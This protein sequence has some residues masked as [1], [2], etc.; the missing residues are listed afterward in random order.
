MV[1]GRSASFALRPTPHSRY[2]LRPSLLAPRSLRPAGFSLAELLIAIAILGVGLAMAAALFPAGILA[3]QNSANDI[4]GTI[5]CQNGQAVAKGL[6]LYSD[7]SERTNLSFTSLNDCKALNVIPEADWLYPS[8]PNSTLKRGFFLLARQVTT[9]LNDYQLVIISYRQITVAGTPTLF[10]TTAY[11]VAGNTK[12]LTF[13][14]VPTNVKWMG[15]PVI[16][17]ATGEHS[18]I[19]EWDGTTA[20]LNSDFSEANGKTVWLVYETGTTPISPAMTVLVTR[21]NLR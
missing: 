20:T 12:K 21:T 1:V 7:V 17:A 9:H 5:I 14:P 13:L 10:S 8:A 3:T 4:L 2:A 19:V 16:I 6:L 11:A 15:S 18:K